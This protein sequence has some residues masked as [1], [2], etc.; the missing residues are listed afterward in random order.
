MARPRILV[1]EDEFL[2]AASLAEDLH[3]LGYDVVGP[4]ATLGAATV[5]VARESFAAAVLD[6]NLSGEMI[7]PLAED[8]LR[9]SVPFLF[10]SGYGLAVIPLQLR[11]RPWL[12]KPADPQTLDR[13]LRKLLQDGA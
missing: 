4:F 12:A 1:V 11:G 9:R 7:Y 13:E 6:V 5:A 2:L 10:L 3:G 8:L